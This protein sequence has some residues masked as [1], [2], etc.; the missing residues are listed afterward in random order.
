MQF[1]VERELGVTLR[2]LPATRITGKLGS[3]SNNVLF[4]QLEIVIY[5]NHAAPD[6]LRVL[7]VP[8][9]EIARN[10]PAAQRSEGQHAVVQAPVTS[11]SKSAFLAL[12][13]RA[14]GRR[15]QTQ[16]GIV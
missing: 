15:D 9:A 4:V 14:L 3:S 8:L 10:G 6:A 12:V 7:P 16:Q 13:C 2:D 5:Q 11:L 1:E